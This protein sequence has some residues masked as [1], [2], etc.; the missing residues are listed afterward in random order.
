M[1]IEEVWSVCQVLPQ[2]SCGIWQFAQLDEELRHTEG[3]RL[4][5]LYTVQDLDSG[6]LAPELMLLSLIFYG[7]FV[8]VYIV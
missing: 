8:M 5:M 3:A 4:A 6:P 2:Q 1:L 7:K